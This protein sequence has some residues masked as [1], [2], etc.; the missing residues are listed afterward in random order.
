MVNLSASL[1]TVATYE[2]TMV[3]PLAVVAIG[4]LIVSLF[5]RP[6][7]IR[8][9]STTAEPEVVLNV[10]TAPPLLTVDVAFLAAVMV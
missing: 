10:G 4:K 3:M 5:A 7:A 1:A 9:T 2:P 8:P 6:C